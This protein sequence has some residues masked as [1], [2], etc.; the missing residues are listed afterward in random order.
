MR[1]MHFKRVFHRF[2]WEAI[3]VTDVTGAYVDGVWVEDSENAVTRT[4]EAIPLA[5]SNEELRLVPDGEDSDGGI[6]LT[7]QAELYFTDINATEQTTTQSYVL[8]QGYRWR[9]VGTNLMRGNV[10]GLNI[11]TALRYIR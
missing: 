11:Y 4:I 8:Y 6:T 10:L 9:V 2:K 5:L 3:E 1:Q 7:T